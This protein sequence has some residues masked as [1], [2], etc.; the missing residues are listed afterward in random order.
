MEK[1]EFENYCTAG[2]IANKIR[3]YIRSFIKKDMKLID[4]AEGIDK[5]IEEF[6]AKPAFP[7]NLSLNEIAAHYTPSL[8]DET[9]AEGILKIDIGVEKEGYIADMAFTIDLTENK[10]YG[11]MI[12]LNEEIL[13]KTINSLNYESKVGDIG[14]KISELLENKPFNIISNLTGHSLEQYQIHSNI[15]IQNTRNGNKT[16]LKEEAV[17]IEPFLTTGQGEVIEGKLSEIFMLINEKNTRDPGTRKLLEFIKE[18]YKT[19]PFC[20][21]WLEKKGF[22]TRFSLATLTKEGILYNFPIL[23]EKSKSPVSQAEET[24]I[25]HNEKKIITTRL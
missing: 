5:K 21:R 6:G 9:K 24:I 17:A 25:F 15:T 10:K 22:R 20:R 12:K 3:K 16:P 13:E 8:D 18:E 2:E 23:I 1:D 7:V 14:N 11:E 19:K 4:I